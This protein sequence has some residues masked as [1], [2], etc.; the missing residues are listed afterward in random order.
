LGDIIIK[1]DYNKILQKYTKATI[2]MGGGGS[3]D[4][5][6]SLSS[7][8]LLT[9]GMFHSFDISYKLVEEKNSKHKKYETGLNFIIKF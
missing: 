3:P 9:G 7:K 6:L 2:E 4:R 8:V 5:G 1:L